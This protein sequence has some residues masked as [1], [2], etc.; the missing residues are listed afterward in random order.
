MATRVEE[1]IA[2]TTYQVLSSLREGAVAELHVVRHEVFAKD[3][4]RKRVDLF[5]IDEA[6]GLQEPRL[7]ED[8]EHPNIVKV[9]EAHHDPGFPGSRPL[10]FYMDYYPERSILTA[11]ESA[12]EFPILDTVRIVRDV[13]N[14]LQYVHEVRQYVHR[15]V[16]PA[17]ILLETGRTKGL[18]ADFGEAAKLGNDGKVAASGGSVLYH[19]PEWAAGRV[20]PSADIYALGLILH[21]MLSGPFD[22]ASYDGDEASNRIKKGWR[23]IP[24]RDLVPASHVPR[25]LQRVVRRAIHRDPERRFQRAADFRGAL[26]AS[27]VIGWRRMA[28]GWMGPD[29][30]SSCTYRV[31]EEPRRS[32]VRLAALRQTH[33]GG[34]WRRFGVDDRDVDPSD[35]AA[36]A[37]FFDD[38]LARAFHRSAS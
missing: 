38:T 19:S 2:A 37:T 21:E 32:V 24:D 34:P 4:V 17:N 18:L 30:G 11:L 28:D 1:R 29:S 16:K 23:A 35:E 22:Y 8:I 7:L 5:G 14:A 31:V 26:M 10:C 25:Q 15:D 13:L 20:A 27:R 9:H 33:R 12:Y 6:I 3:R 36:Y